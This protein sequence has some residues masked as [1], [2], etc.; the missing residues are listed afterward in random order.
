[1][2]EGTA[3]VRDN[4][5]LTFMRGGEWV[6]ETRRAPLSAAECLAVIAEAEE[7][8][9]ADAAGGSVKHSS[10][11]GWGTAR[12]YSVPTTD[13]AVRDLPRTLSWFNDAMRRR[14]GPLVAAAA[15][16]GEGRLHPESEFAASGSV[17]GDVPPSGD[18]LSGSLYDGTAADGHKDSERALS[19]PL[20]YERTSP[21]ESVSNFVRRLRI[22]D[23]FVVRYDAEAQRSLPLHTDQ[24]ELSLTIS[25]NH[26]SEYDGG[27]TWFESLGRAVRPE[28]AG[29]VVVFP[30]GETVH[31]G[32]EITR[33]VR[34]VLA[35]FLYEH[36]VEEEEGDL[37]EEDEE[38]EEDERY[39]H[40][41]AS[42]EESE[43]V[44]EKE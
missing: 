40:G 36:R 21:E 11:G 37:G 25:L 10:S 19:Q 42:V 26:G 7:K 5:D 13:M 4:L 31:G 18:E 9:A 43:G 30:G 29:H 23:A 2:A 16:L 24:G 41:A 33:G 22:H 27:G 15:L 44:G 35:V 20:A 14:I 28:D 3:S 39:E 6:C 12:H 34:Y 38:D 8:A 1:M 32:R 17:L